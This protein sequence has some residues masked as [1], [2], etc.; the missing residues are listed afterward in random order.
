MKRFTVLALF[1]ISACFCVRSGA[2]DLPKDCSNPGI[3]LSC[4]LVPW[5]VPIPETATREDGPWRAP[6]PPAVQDARAAITIA[7]AEWQSMHPHANVGSDEDW[8]K[9]FK[10]TQAD[11][12]WEV[13][14]RTWSDTHGAFVAYIKAQDG[15]LMGAKYIP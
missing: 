3:I 5:E 1:C 13:A 7:H 14:T 12:V 6:L 4:V 11:G 2:A 8:Q 10:A 9:A 15:Q